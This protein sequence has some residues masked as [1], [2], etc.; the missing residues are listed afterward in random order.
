MALSDDGYSRHGNLGNSCIRY[1]VLIYLPDGNK[2]Y[3]SR[4]GEFEGIGSVGD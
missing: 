3:G 2:V 1:V 4:G